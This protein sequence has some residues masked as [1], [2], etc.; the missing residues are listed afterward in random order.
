MAPIR[1]WQKAKKFKLING[2]YYPVSLSEFSAI[3][4]TLSN[5]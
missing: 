5:T 4:M 2:F 1:L 3:P